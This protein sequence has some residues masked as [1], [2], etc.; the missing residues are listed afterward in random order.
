MELF[1][2]E[3]SPEQHSDYYSPR[4]RVPIKEMGDLADNIKDAQADAEEV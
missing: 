1:S 3:H 4:K 2:A